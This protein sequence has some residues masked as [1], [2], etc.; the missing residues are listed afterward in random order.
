MF[1][2]AKDGTI[3][4]RSR[5]VREAAFTAGEL[6]SQSR[7]IK[8]NTYVQQVKAAPAAYTAYQA[9][10]RLRGRRACDLAKAD[11][12]HPPAITDVDLSQHTGQPGQPI[13]VQAVDDFEVKSV[14]LTF[15]R[16]DGVLIETGAA[17]FEAGS[18]SWRYVTQVPVACGG[19]VVVH[20]TVS[21]HPGNQV[22]KTFEHALVALA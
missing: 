15:T 16:L 22:T 13:C 7:L 18:A 1:A 6:K 3:S 9:A 2:R 21:D 4:V 10:A 14:Q 12:A 11:F 5:P 8:G 19:V 20:V 17:I